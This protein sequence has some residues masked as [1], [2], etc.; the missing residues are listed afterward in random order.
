M[1]KPL[2]LR[3]LALSVT[4]ALVTVSAPAAQPSQDDFAKLKD[5]V[6]Q[7]NTQQQQILASLDELKKMMKG[8]TQPALKPP[9]TMTV[10]GEL[11]KGEPSAKVAVIEYA[12]FQCP[13]CRRFESQI[14]PNIRDAY[15]KTGKLKYFH[16]DMP[17]AF[18]QG[19][20]PAARAV[21]CASEQGKFWEMHDTL[22]GDAASLTPAD[23][24]QR[25]GQL[26]MDVPKLDQCISSD[27]F[28]DII[29]RSINEASAMQ[30]SG[31]P[32]FIIGT[33]DA[34]GNLMSVKKTVV[35]ASPFEAFKAAID[36]LL[37][38]N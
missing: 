34:N 20:M 5:Q 7:L 12:D 30:V 27:R 22:L 19:A 25:A 21:H 15:I 36:P 17:L 2:A 31:T 35:G 33:L 3:A 23:I 32:T 26:G 8:P 6:A 16:R 1:S 14:Y 38:A 37:A 29:Q 9:P 10:T 11:Y 13:F 4:A 24:D 18:H 28:A